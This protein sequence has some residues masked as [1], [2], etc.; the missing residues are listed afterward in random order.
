M[1]TTTK[2]FSEKQLWEFVN[3]AD[4][5]E[6]IQI[7]DD[8]L[9]KLDYLDIEVYNDMMDA[10]AYKSRELYRHDDEDEI[11]DYDE[12]MDSYRKN[13]DEYGRYLCRCREY[14]L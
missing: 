13:Q 14:N 5:H 8:F 11:E 9:S 3:R 7:A 12:Y 10:L 1:A 4:T 6:K 2:R